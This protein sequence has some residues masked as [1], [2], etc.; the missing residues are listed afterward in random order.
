MASAAAAWGLLATL[1]LGFA[2][3]PLA[4][5]PGPCRHAARLAR[6]RLAALLAFAHPGAAGRL[7]LVLR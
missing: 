5:G 3:W 2:Y 4:G 7:T 1:V 6:A